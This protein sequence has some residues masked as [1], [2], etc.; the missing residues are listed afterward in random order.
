MASRYY[1]FAGD[2]EFKITL[3]SFRSVF[4]FSKRFALLW[5][6]ISVCHYR[7]VLDTQLHVYGNNIRNV[8]LVFYNKI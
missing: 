3:R 5:F 2:K 1:S 8:V 6:C 7:I 4:H